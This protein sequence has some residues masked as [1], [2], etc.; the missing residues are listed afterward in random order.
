MPDE[1]VDI[2]NTNASQDA[3]SPEVPEFIR[4]KFDFTDELLD[5][6]DFVDADTIVVAYASGG[7]IKVKEFGDPFAVLGVAKVAIQILEDDFE[8]VPTCGI[9]GEELEDFEDEG[10]IKDEV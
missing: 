5:D 6:F 2:V 1:T 9:C 8:P 7:R 10:I 4:E 3:G